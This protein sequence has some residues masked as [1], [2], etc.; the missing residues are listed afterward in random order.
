MQSVYIQIKMQ[1]L[2]ENSVPGKP[3]SGA[4]GNIY[5]H[6]ELMESSVA[7]FEEKSWEF[8]HEALGGASDQAPP[9]FSA[10]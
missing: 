5:T 6:G 4:C 9:G 3:L 8:H 2:W 10:S 1:L 7:A